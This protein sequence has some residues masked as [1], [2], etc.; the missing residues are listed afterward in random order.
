MKMKTMDKR[1]DDV[2]I[3]IKKK[4]NNYKDKKYID[5]PI[6]YIYDDIIENYKIPII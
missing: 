6:K 5:K 1:I 2:F 4:S 3:N